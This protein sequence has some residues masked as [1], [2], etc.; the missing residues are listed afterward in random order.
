MIVTEDYSFLYYFV[1]PMCF[2][3]KIVLSLHDGNSGLC[4][5]ILF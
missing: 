4:E 5:V 3:V 1:H 2:V